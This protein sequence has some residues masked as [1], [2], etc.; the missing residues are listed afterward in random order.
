MEDEV[1]LITFT[2]GLLPGVVKKPDMFVYDTERGIVQI[3]D[4]E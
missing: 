2:R 1:T 3:L 4:K